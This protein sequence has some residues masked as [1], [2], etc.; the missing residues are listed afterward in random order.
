MKK[1]FVSF[2]AIA[3]IAVMSGHVNAQVTETTSAGA[4]IISPISIVETSPLHF[5]SMSV[6]SHLGGTCTLSTDN[7]RTQTGEVSLS[8]AGTPHSTASY[9]VYGGGNAA[10][11][12]TLP[13]TI[14]VL[15]EANIP[16]TIVDIKAKPASSHV[17]ATTGTLSVHGTDTFTVGGT[18][19]VATAQPTGNYTGTFNV[20]VAYN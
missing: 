1:L 10:Y 5:G 9:E 11:V 7:V 16:M 6:T 15:N 19:I 8:S 17:D 20:T 13:G 12:I 14:T 2:V 4:Y 3:A 18:L